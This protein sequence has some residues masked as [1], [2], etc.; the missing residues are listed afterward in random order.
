MSEAAFVAISGLQHLVFCERQAALI[1]VERQWREDAATAAGRLL[2]ER[3]DARGTDH[4][5]GVRV[6]RGVP[7]TS[8][9]LGLIGRA[10]VV[11]YHGEPSG[12]WRPVPVEYKRGRAGHRLADRVQLCAQAICLEERHRISIPS[13][14]LFYGKSHRRVEVYFDDELRRRTAEAARRLHDL[15][16]T[17]TVPRVPRAPKCA[18]C[19][20]ESLCLPDVTAAAGAA[21]RY[22]ELL[23]PG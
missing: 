3:V 9:R 23:V 20:L 15:V 12:N 6:E 22:L 19:S 1:H 21:G 17:G 7:L 8:E 4:R 14:A 10:D 16:R 2:H 18:S 13:G 11:E 5:P